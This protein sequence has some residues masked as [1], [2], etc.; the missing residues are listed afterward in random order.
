MALNAAAEVGDE[1]LLIARATA[2]PVAVAGSRVDAA[3]ALL[4]AHA[5][6]DVLVADDALQH[7]RLARDIEIAVFDDRGLGNGWVLPAG[8]LREPAGRLGTVDAI[9]LHRTSKSPVAAVPC[10]ALHTALGQDAYRLGDR[11]QTMTLHELARRQQAAPTTITAAAGTGVPQRFF[12]MLRAAGLEI[13]PL[14]LP[15]HYDYRASPFTANRADLVLI[16]EKDAVKC[17]QIDAVCSDPRIWVVPLVATIDT[18]FIDF[19]V[20]RLSQRQ[21]SPHGP[22]VA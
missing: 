9:V 8:P 16:T 2:A 13:Q 1:P 3:H 15:D 19:L 21:K 17:E 5:A 12:D 7:L 18:A 22:S 6:C 10:F 14:P 11:T 4:R 20:A